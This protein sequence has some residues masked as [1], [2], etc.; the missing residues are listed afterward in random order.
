MYTLLIVI[1]STYVLWVYLSKC[2]VTTCNKNKNSLCDWANV[3]RLQD[4]L[5]ASCLSPVAKDIFISCSCKA[6]IAAFSKSTKIDAGCSPDCKFFSAENKRLYVSSVIFG[7]RAYALEITLVCCCSNVW[8]TI[9]K[10]P[11]AF[12]KIR[13]R[14]SGRLVNSKNGYSN[15]SFLH[16]SNTINSTNVLGIRV[17][18]TFF[19]RAHKRYWR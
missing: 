8:Y 12:E 17:T 5:L 14:C 3:L 4:D 11:Q 7:R 1:Y 9:E 10:T 18:A 2:S 16:S 19:W 13:M 6:F 15:L